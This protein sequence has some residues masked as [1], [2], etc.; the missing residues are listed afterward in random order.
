MKV[1]FYAPMKPPSSPVPSGDRQ[2]ARALMAALKLRGHEV[3]L[4]SRFSARDG[5]GD[6]VRQQRLRDIGGRL[7]DR[8]I[9]R[10]RGQPAT[11]PD[12]WFTY[13]LYYKAP[14]WIGPQVADTLGIP[15]VIAEASYAPK[16]AG[17][18]WDIGHQGA[19]D[20]ISM[21]DR[22]FELNPI[23][24][25]CVQ[26]LLKNSAQIVPLAP[27]IDR[28]KHPAQDRGSLRRSIAAETGLDPTM[29][30][31]L[32]VAMM[33][34]GAKFRSYRVLAQA[35]VH[36]N[37][38]PWQLLIAGDGPERTAIA[39]M[40]PPE[41]VCFLGERSEDT[42]PPVFEAADIYVWPAINEAYGMS[43]LEAQISGL[44]VI[45][46]DAGGVGSIVQ[47]GETGVLVTEGDVIG[48]ARAVR[49]LLKDTQTRTKM[50]ANAAKWAARHHSLSA[51]ADRL[52]Q[53]LTELVG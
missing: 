46:G 8:I 3:Q 17:G 9:K 6:P 52:D 24:T 12:A 43:L 29:P 25:P 5:K 42:L 2:M 22:I 38:L 13:H 53:T 31:L 37:D 48:F 51:A 23:N 11:V 30:W 16:R 28:P 34:D 35:L 44:P 33:R 41:R 1:A 10:Y 4:A 14:D 7:A 40:F 26:P 18:P 39:A 19:A 20:A 47:D 15:Y 45:A 27:F 49:G 21:A 50:A 32:T 36:L